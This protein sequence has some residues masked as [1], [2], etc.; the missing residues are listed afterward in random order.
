M[1][2]QWRAAPSTSKCWNTTQMATATGVGA[3]VLTTAVVVVT[4]MQMTAAM[5]VKI[6]TPA[7]VTSGAALATNVALAMS[8]AAVA[9]SA[10]P[11]A[12]NAHR[13]AMLLPATATT[14]PRGAP[15]ATP[16][17][18]GTRLQQ[19][20][21]TPAGQ[22]GT[23]VMQ[24]TP[25]VA[26]AVVPDMRM[27]HMTQVR[28]VAVIV[29]RPA[30]ALNAMQPT[31][32]LVTAMQSVPL[33]AAVQATQMTGVVQVAAMH[34]Q[35]TRSVR[36]VV[37]LLPVDMPRSATMIG[38][39]TRAAAGTRMPPTTAVPGGA[40]RST[41]PPQEATPA[42]ETGWPAQSGAMPAAGL[43]AGSVQ[44]RL[45]PMSAADAAAL[46]GPTLLLL[47]HAVTSPTKGMH[48]VS[49]Q[50]RAQLL[51]QRMRCTIIHLVA[52]GRPGA[53]QLH[54]CT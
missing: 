44:L 8:V 49:C 51:Q 10:V 37:E 27:L 23:A 31:T 4:A 32:T 7:L 13:T 26:T 22:V 39:C 21:A 42:V 20:T 5:S 15:V 18:T 46:T 47:M 14:A 54:D 35:S 3:A 52:C 1:G 2:A 19:A 34:M 40:T 29:M 36:L 25:S 53:P 38:P 30:L 48:W 41:P 43:L 16:V 17:Q 28:G 11:V 45:L 50:A 12:M 33:P 6:A 9:T 24:A